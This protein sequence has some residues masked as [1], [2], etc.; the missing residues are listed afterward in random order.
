MTVFTIGH[1]NAAIDRFLDLLRQHRIEVLVDTRS[2]PYSRYVP[3]FNRESLSATLQLAGLGYL[4][5][6]DSLG[7]R[8]AER[9][10]YREDGK[11]DYDL[12]AEAPFYLAGL[13]QLKKQAETGRVA[14][15]CSEAD[16]HKC[17]RYWLIT[18]S[19]AGEGVEVRH[20]LHSG[21]MATTDPKEFESSSD[22]LRLF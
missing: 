4:Y 7:G 18:R 9:Q 8:P 3:Q 13:G 14:V 19:L 10:Y 2:Q 5:M 16:Y 12:L 21:E 20:I 22:Q 11:V 6:G 1:S 17:H 15:L